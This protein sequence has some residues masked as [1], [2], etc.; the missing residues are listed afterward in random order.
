ML[1]VSVPPVPVVEA[2]A[3]LRVE[4]GQRGVEVGVAALAAIQGVGAAAAAD[5]VVEGR[6]GDAVG[7]VVAVDG[8]A[9][10]IGGGIDAVGGR[11][12]GQRTG[13]SLGAQGN[14]LDADE[15]G[16]A[17]SRIEVEGVCPR[18]VKDQVV[19]AAT[20]VDGSAEATLHDIDRVAAR[21]GSPR[22]G[23]FG[24]A[25]IGSGVFD[26]G[27]HDETPRKN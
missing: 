8:Q 4:V 23:E 15:A 25:D 20:A 13:G 7:A 12:G 2:G 22:N 14:D 10:G 18:L 1:T 6:A 27:G 9:V 17:R 16:E 26:D 19:A 21:A 11:A 24:G 3:L 5:D